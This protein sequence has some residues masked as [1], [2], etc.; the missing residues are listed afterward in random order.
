MV[1][2][3]R[4]C[5]C[6]NRQRYDEV[7]KAPSLSDLPLI[8]YSRY[9]RTTTATNI[10]SS[11][12]CLTEPS[13]SDTPTPTPSLGS[14]SRMQDFRPLLSRSIPA[15]SWSRTMVLPFWTKHGCSQP[16]CAWLSYAYDGRP[17]RH[18]IFSMIAAFHKTSLTDVSG[19]ATINCWSTSE[20]I[21]LPLS[22]ATPHRILASVYAPNR[23][24]RI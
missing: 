22:L 17:P 19:G 21:S 20:N 11:L 10:S 23:K 15:F 5:D 8:L 13:L 12:C 18:S 1:N 14:I 16:T 6:A 2:E 24:T 4:K 9:F 7:R 3:N